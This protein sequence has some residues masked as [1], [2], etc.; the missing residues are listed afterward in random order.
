M[1]IDLHVHSHFSDGADTVEEVLDLAKNSGIELVSFV[2]HDTTETFG[3]AKYLAKERNIKLV[4]GIEI[5]AYDFK[6]QRKVH[7]LGYQYNQAA[8]HIKEI[9]DELL[10]RRHE[11]SLHQ[12]QKI[13]EVGYDIDFHKLKTAVN[14]KRTLYKQQIMAAITEAPYETEEYQTLYR[15]LFKGEGAASGDI[16]YIDAY[17][18]V[19][20]IKAD[21]GL[22]VIAHPGQL[23]SFDLIEELIAYEL[24]GVEMY[25]P[26]HSVTDISRTRKLAEKYDLLETG[27][28]DYHGKFW[29]SKTLGTNGLSD[30]LLE[31]LSVF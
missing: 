30:H 9:C 16:E 27:G 25:H 8:T 1:K 11:H 13:Q 17:S 22:A 28:S 15:S 31:K 12:L 4:P 19:N 2:D 6:R 18:A 3:A 20:A 5:S 21:G 23:N 29:T 26:D 10:E 7:V 24:D 14:S